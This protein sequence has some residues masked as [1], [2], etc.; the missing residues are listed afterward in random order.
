MPGSI[1]EVPVVAQPTSFTCGPSSLKAVLAFHGRRVSMRRLRA[2]CG[3]TGDGTDHD[4]LARG[5][6]ALGARVVCKENGTLAE[7]ARFVGQG[8]PV[9]VGWWSMAP[10]DLPFDRRWTL[11]QRRAHDCGH[12]SVC[13]GVGGDRV[14]LMDPQEDQRTARVVG[15]TSMNRHRFLSVW[16][17]T[18]TSAYR[19]VKRW[20]AVVEFDDRSSSA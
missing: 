8:L 18:D 9:I 2:L 1:L 5:A 19:P 11:P 13:T 6:A 3:T 14:W 17:D 7:L 15:R 4:N 20:F 10:D 16:Y 12:Y